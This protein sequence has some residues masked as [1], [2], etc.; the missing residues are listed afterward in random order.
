MDRYALEDAAR[1]SLRYLEKFHDNAKLNAVMGRIYYLKGDHRAVGYLNRVKNNRMIDG[2]LATALYDELMKND[3]PAEKHLREILKKNPG[4][5]SPHI[6]LA[7]IALRRGEGVRAT[8]LLP[9]FFRQDLRP[10][11]GSSHAVHCY[12]IPEIYFYLPEF[13]RP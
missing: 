5:I 1:Y 13:E 9:V 2:V 12:D 4:Y 11:Q 3:G 6:A 8:V 7:R 10:R